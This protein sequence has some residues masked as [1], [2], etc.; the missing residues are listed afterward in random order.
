MPNSNL[1]LHNEQCRALRNGEAQLHGIFGTIVTTTFS[2]EQRNLLYGIYHKAGAESCLSAYNDIVS[3]IE[4]FP[5]R[6]AN[7]SI[8]SAQVRRYYG[9]RATPNP[10]HSDL[11]SFISRLHDKEAKIKVCTW[12][13]LFSFSPISIIPSLYR[14]NILPQI[15]KKFKLFFGSYLRRSLL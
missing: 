14:F 1:G 6:Y 7:A 5:S 11:I 3:K 13:L 2:Q 8:T 4:S 9:S 15:P 12:L 10:G